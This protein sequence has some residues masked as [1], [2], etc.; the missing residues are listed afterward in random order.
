MAAAAVAAAE[1]AA[2][3]ESAAK[4]AE[5]AEQK[6]VVSVGVIIHRPR[7][8]G[9]LHVAGGLA[10]ASRNAFGAGLLHRAGIGCGDGCRGDRRRGRPRRQ[11]R[12]DITQFDRQ[13]GTPSVVVQ[14]WA[15]SRV[16][17]H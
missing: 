1:S 14:G 17:V 13:G 7:G 15:A 4:A 9:D 16:A 5:A 10:F 6:A 12:C 3:A 8:V 2:V 11:Q